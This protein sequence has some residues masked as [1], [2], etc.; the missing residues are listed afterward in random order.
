M[1]PGQVPASGDW[2]RDLG[3]PEGLHVRPE[4]DP[5]G[6]RCLPLSSGRGRVSVQGSACAWCARSSVGVRRGHVRLC[7]YECAHTVCA[8][9]HEPGGQMCECGCAW[10]S[11]TTLH[12]AHTCAS[13]CAISG[14]GQPV[15]VHV[16][17]SA[18]GR[19]AE[20]G[21]E[22]GQRSLEGVGSAGVAIA[23]CP[24]LLPE[25]RTGEDPGCRPGSGLP[26]VWPW[27]SP[28]RPLL[29]LGLRA[30]SRRAEQQAEQQRG[31]LGS[32]CG[33]LEVGGASGSAPGRCLGARTHWHSPGGSAAAF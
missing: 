4:P 7:M 13:M 20:K 10:G 5:P 1:S 3:F 24:E 19:S 17:V 31:A 33:G 28:Q 21:D 27:P 14:L 26:R 11:S 23:G 18:E 16:C 32:G 6:W 30:R 15:C 12:L 9:V 25:P 8:C 2:G 29:P 22:W